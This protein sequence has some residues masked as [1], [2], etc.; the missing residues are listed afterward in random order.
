MLRTELPQLPSSAHSYQFLVRK[1]LSVISYHISQ[2]MPSLTSSTSRNEHDDTNKI[3]TKGKGFP[4][5]LIH[6]FMDH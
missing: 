5:T 4:V 3:A 6:D 1:R 2:E